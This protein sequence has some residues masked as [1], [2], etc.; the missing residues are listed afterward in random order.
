VPAFV[1]ASFFASTP[2]SRSASDGA[3]IALAVKEDV[4]KLSAENAG[5][6]DIWP[7]HTVRP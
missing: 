7:V 2:H 4:G 6:P 3:Q 1:L 5:R